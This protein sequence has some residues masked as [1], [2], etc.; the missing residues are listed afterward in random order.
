MVHVEYSFDGAN[1]ESSTFCKGF[2]GI[3]EDYVAAGFLLGQVHKLFCMAK[4][5]TF[6]DLPLYVL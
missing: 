5:T 3:H 6:M 4:E 2:P 1:S